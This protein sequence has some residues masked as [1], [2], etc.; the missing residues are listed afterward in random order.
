MDNYLTEKGRM[1]IVWTTFIALALII[2]NVSLFSQVHS[3]GETSKEPIILRGRVVDGD[4]LP[5]V[6]LNEV[7]IF[8]PW[9]FASQKE[10]LRYSKLVRNVK[11]TLPYARIASSKLLEISNELTK[12]K[13]EKERKKFLKEAEKELFAEFEGPLRKLSFSQGK[14]LIRLIDRETGS[15]SYDLIKQYRGKVTAFF[16]QG[17]ARIFGA[18]L[19]DEYDPS[20][21]DKMVEYIIMLI[22]SGQI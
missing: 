21:D 15:T 2:S 20:R 1:K 5:H 4:T 9:K 7:I 17:M 16:W 13:G 14:M 10:Y 18:N 19:K 12:I 3:S 8:P 11:I 22:D 6:V